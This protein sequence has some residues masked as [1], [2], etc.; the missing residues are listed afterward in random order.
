MEHGQPSGPRPVA[1]PRQHLL[2][3]LALLVFLLGLSWPSSPAASPGPAP[4]PLEHVCLQLQ[5][6]EGL[7]W[8]QLDLDALELP[9]A[10]GQRRLAYD[11]AALT[12]TLRPDELAASGP[13]SVAVRLVLS[14]IGVDRLLDNTHGLQEAVALLQL[15][16]NRLTPDV[17]DPLHAQ[18]YRP[19]PGCDQDFVACANPRQ[20]LAL[21]TRRALAPAELHA[22]ARLIPAV[23]LAVIAWRL[24]RGHEVDDLSA[25][26]TQFVH[27]CG[28]AAY[29]APTSACDEPA[30][31]ARGASAHDGPMLLR[32]PVSLSPRGHYR[33][34]EVARIPYSPRSESSSGLAGPLPGVRPLGLS[35]A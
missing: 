21:A 13:E 7:R 34:S 30:E 18:G 8:L 26:A 3:A 9:G 19:Y 2:P 5:A 22:P 15:V 17:A 6:C 25:G 24:V 4:S 35:G 23:D 27:R 33:L 20:F 16:R 31:R 11:P 14:E 29:G 1:D 10:S 12:R 28:G 32:A